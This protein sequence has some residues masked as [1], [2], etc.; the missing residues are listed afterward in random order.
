MTNNND[1]ILYELAKAMRGQGGHLTAMALRALARH[2][3]T[4]L[5]EV[6]GVTDCE[7]L[8]IGG[9]GPDRLGA[10]RRLTRPDWQPPSRQAIRTAGRLLSAAQLALHFWSVEDLKAILGGNKLAAGKDK[11][12]ETELSLK[13]FANAASEAASHHDPAELLRI[14]QRAGALRS[15]PSGAVADRNTR[16]R[17]IYDPS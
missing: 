2:G 5:A 16:T 17:R 4:S 15:T 14:V 6:D 8:A 11:P 13:A 10:I 3:Y 1:N 9:I 7:L 12:I